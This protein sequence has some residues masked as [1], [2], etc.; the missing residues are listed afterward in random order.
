MGY[1][2]VSSATPHSSVLCP[3]NQRTLRL[4][5]YSFSSGTPITTVTFGDLL[6]PQLF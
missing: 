1:E 4:A 2:E 3:L 6:W 5:C